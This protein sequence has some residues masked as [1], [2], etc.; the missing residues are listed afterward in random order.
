MAVRAKSPSKSS[1][2]AAAAKGSADDLAVLNSDVPTTIAGRKLVMREYGF[3]EGMRLQGLYAPFV[4]DLYNSMRDSADV[5]LHEVIELLGRHT[6]QVAEL[7]SIAA[8][9]ELNWVRGLDD[10]NGMNLMYLWWNVNCPFFMRRVFDRRSAELA[11]EK[12]RAGETSMP[13]S[14]STDTAPQ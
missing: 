1:K 5:P 3:I 6:D 9:V 4:T 10:V 2:A 7:I 8:D 12:V 14:S 13:S 11:V